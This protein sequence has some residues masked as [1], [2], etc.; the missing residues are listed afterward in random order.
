MEDQIID[1]IVVV[2]TVLS[3][4]GDA[5][6]I[7]SEY[8]ENFS[9]TAFKPWKIIAVEN[10]PRLLFR[11]PVQFR[12][13]RVSDTKFEAAPALLNP[14]DMVSTSVYLT[15]TQ[16]DAFAT[17]KG[18]EANVEWNARITNL[19]RFSEP[20][21]IFERVRSRNFGIQV[22]MQGWALPFTIVCALLFQ[23][24]HLHLLSRA[25]FLHGWSGYSIGLILCVSLLSFAAAESSATYLFESDTT[26]IYGLNHW[27]NLPP[28]LANILALVYLDRKAKTRTA[29][30]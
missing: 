14:G 24:V 28:I 26:E 23:A 10:S 22:Q 17:E 30:T 2:Q 12:W 20:P 9:V 25:G 13:K 15:N 29:Y 4:L 21:D 1:N 11:S 6:I 19:R 3:N 5:P 7:P 18:P 8:H 27:L 16:F